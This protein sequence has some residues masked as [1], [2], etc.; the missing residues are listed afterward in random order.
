[1]T[2]ITWTPNPTDPDHVRGEPGGYLVMIQRRRSGVVWHRLMYE[3][4]KGWTQLDIANSLDAAKAYAEEHYGAM[5]KV[6]S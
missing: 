2:A 5:K 4:R 1:M 3:G 6:R